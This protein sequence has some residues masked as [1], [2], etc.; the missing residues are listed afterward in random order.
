MPDHRA[1][2]HCYRIIALLIAAALLFAGTTATQLRA[3]DPATFATDDDTILRY[4]PV[5]Q[6]MVS[7]PAPELRPGYVY[8]H[9]SPTS[10]RRVWSYV[11]ADGTFWHAFGP[12]TTIEAPR[13]DLRVTR[14]ELLEELDLTA[15]DL[16]KRVREGLRPIRFTLD[17]QGEWIESGS[18]RVLSVF[19][20]DTR[21]RWE[22]HWAKYLPVRNLAGSRWT[23]D[24]GG[25]QPVVTSRIASHP[26]APCCTDP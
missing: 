9:F 21:Q 18:S 4:D 6:S 2:R 13:F 17:D 10:K 12:G 22:K 7:V 20:A 16:A 15:P 26:S 23:Y 8:N 19:D 5:R 14:R 11:Q 3:D 25:Y 1:A 24:E